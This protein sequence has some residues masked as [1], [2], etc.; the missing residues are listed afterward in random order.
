MQ[1]NNAQSLTRN[2]QP[3]IQRSQFNRSSSFKTTFDAGN[4]IPIYLDEVL[5]GDT[6]NMKATCFARMATPIFPIMDNL[7]FDTQWFFCPTRLLYK[8]FKKQMGEVPVQGID[9]P[10]NYITPT[11]D[12][13]T[14]PPAG[15]ALNS[16]YDYLGLPI[17]IAQAPMV[18]DIISLPFRMY[19]FI[20]NEWYIDQS[21]QVP[22]SFTD[23]D[24]T[25]DDYADYTILRRGKRKDY[26]TSAALYPQKL[27]SGD[28]VPTLP[29]NSSYTGL[30]TVV[31]NP[32]TGAINKSR[33]RLSTNGNVAGTLTGAQFGVNT[34]DLYDSLN[35]QNLTLDPNGSLA[36]QLDAAN[37]MGTINEL[38]VAVQMQRFLELDNRAGTRYPELTW[39]HFGVVTPDLMYRPEYLGGSSSRVNITPVQQTSETNT[40][41][42]GNLAAQGTLSNQA[43]WVKSFTEHGYIMGLASVRADMSY[44]Q[45][46][47][48]LWTTRL[49]RYDYYWP[50]FAHLGEQPIYTNE[51][52]ASTGTWLASPLVWAYAERYAEYKFKNSL[53]TSS[54]RSQAP[55]S[56]DAWHLAQEYTV[57]PT[58]G[59]TFIVENPPVDRVIAVPAEPHFIMD[60]DFKLN[61]ARAMP[62]YSTPGM[63]DHF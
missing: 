29:Y 2:Q 60:C 32:T 15:F 62:T 14:Y 56:L 53:I 16:I 28:N 22:V 48:R 8:N 57:A 3:N 17:L 6:F 59:A 1:S 42:Q 23:D 51:L 11:M 13:A 37:F 49:T 50:T 44:Q 27:W 21:L 38:R 26:F 7:Y 39:A 36:V 54:F 9:N 20:Y 46:V 45:N 35:A 58:L 25:P 18:M 43:K 63:M 61:C 41:P 52:F 19:N 4:L 24:T 12:R 55:T 30:E 10:N 34:G 5:P 40:T 33:L 47:D 31:L